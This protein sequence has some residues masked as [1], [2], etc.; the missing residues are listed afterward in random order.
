MKFLILRFSSIGD[1]VL[2]SPVARCLKKKFP[3]AEIHYATKKSF[4][5]IVQYNPYLNKIHLL[6]ESLMNLISELRKEKFDYI[7]DVPGNDI[8]ARRT[9]EQS[10]MP[11]GLMDNFS[12]Q[13]IADLL[14]WLKR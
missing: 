11:A 7:I 14:A 4:Q 8:A 2:T 3:E 12:D 9:S 5:S 13:Q 6:D 10:L 1:I